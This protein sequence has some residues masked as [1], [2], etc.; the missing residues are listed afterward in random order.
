V[1]R[2]AVTV[3]TTSFRRTYEFISWH[4]AENYPSS[5]KELS[6]QGESLAKAAWDLVYVLEKDTFAGRTVA[7]WCL[8]V[9][10]TTDAL[11]TAMVTFFQVFSSMHGI[12]LSFNRLV[13]C[14]PVP[15]LTDEDAARFK[16]LET[17]TYLVEREEMLGVSS[18]TFQKGKMIAGKKWHELSD[19]FKSTN[20]KTSDRNI[21]SGGSDSSG[22]SSC[23]V[24]G[25][26]T[27]QKCSA[28]KKVHYCSKDCQKINWR[29]HKPL[30]NK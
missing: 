6:I 21:G 17:L 25:K 7:I 26:M 30:C 3:S 23:Y 11:L 18:F 19:S 24:C 1:S 2:Y 13:S 20:K 16:I 10:E 14:H 15:P 22:S 27:T 12:K 29:D 9:E 28:C 4:I 8:D 5:W